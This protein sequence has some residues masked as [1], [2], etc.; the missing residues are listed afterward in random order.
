MRGLLAV[1]VG[2]L[3]GSFVNL[4]IVMVGPELIPL[5]PEIDPTDPE[6]LKAHADLLESK[7]FITPWVAH[8]MGTLVGALIALAIA[9][10]NRAQKAF[11]IGVLFLIGGITAA[12][13]IPA[14]MWFY[15]ADLVLAYVP[16]AWLATKIMGTEDR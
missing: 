16:M 7:H 12:T 6:S 3:I 5:P 15:F 10:V 8:A 2:F 11:I 14:P 1:L 13:M 9:K 4:G